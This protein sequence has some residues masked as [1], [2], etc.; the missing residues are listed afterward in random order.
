[1]SRSILIFFFVLV[2]NITYGQNRV[3]TSKSLLQDSILLNNFWTKFRKAIN[4][5]DK[6]K[7]AALCEFPFYCRPCIDDTTLKV[8]DPVT[9]KVTKK[10]FVES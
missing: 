1:M 8:N 10:L 4:E 6:E 7:L 9:I 5:N 3:I 2:S